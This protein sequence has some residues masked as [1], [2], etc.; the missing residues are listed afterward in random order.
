MKN[1]YTFADIIRHAGGSNVTHWN[2]KS[3]HNAFN[4]ANYCQRVHYET[5]ARPYR[6]E[7]DRHIKSLSLYLS[8]PCCLELSLDALQHA[9]NLLLQTL[10]GNPLLPT[11]LLECIVD[12]CMKTETSRDT[13]V[14]TCSELSKSNSIMET[15]E[16]IFD[17]LGV[18]TED[19]RIESQAETLLTKLKSQYQYSTNSERY[20]QYVFGI[21]K[22][23]S[24]DKK[25]LDI[26]SHLSCLGDG[27]A[28]QK[29]NRSVETKGKYHSRSQE[30]VTNVHPCLED[31]Q[32]MVLK[33]IAED[34]QSKKS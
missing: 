24:K 5:A 15:L 20:R 19:F 11:R 10:V 7:L 1:I 2:E 25:G 27:K 22:Q 13:F 32:E 26:L 29:T 31:I 12:T 8:P 16:E 28:S 23:L 18:S 17:Q 9:E 6:G 30:D 34:D 3:V 4:W 21:L 14:K 33:W